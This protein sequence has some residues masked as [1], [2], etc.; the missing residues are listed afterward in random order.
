MSAGDGRLLDEPAEPVRPEPPTTLD[1]PAPAPATPQPQAIPFTILYED[2]DLIV[3]DKPAGLVVHPAP[4]NQDG[5]LVNAL[6]AHCGDQLYGYRRRTSARA[7]CIGWTRTHP[8]SWWWPR[9]NWRNDRPDRRLRRPRP[10]PRLSCAGAGACRSRLP[11]RSRAPSAATRAIASAWRCVTR[12]GKPALHPLSHAAHLAGRVALL[13]CRLATGRTHQIRVHL[14]A[15]AAIR[16]SATRSTCA[17]SPP[18]PARCPS[19]SA[20]ELA[21]FPSPG[22][23]RGP[24][25][26]RPPAH[27]PALSFATPPPADM[28]GLIDALG[29]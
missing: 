13:E 16:S 7:S 22:A 14:A 15:T 10:R 11:A 26:V 20:A 19:R 21:G 6:L 25:W 27:R 17:A 8:A 12:G 29:C 1:L 3:L 2:A 28:Q 24:A 18:P 23:A 4:G 5:T 9:P